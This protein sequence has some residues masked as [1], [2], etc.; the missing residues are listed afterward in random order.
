[1][2]V[3]F[4]FLSQPRLST[5]L[6]SFTSFLTHRFSSA[7]KIQQ[8]SA[9]NVQLNSWTQSFTED[10]LLFSLSSVQNLA[11]IQL[12]R[13]TLE[14][15]GTLA[16]E[17]VLIQMVASIEKDLQHIFAFPIK[18]RALV[19]VSCILLCDGGQSGAHMGRPD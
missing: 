1:M 14:T 3:S 13:Q 16:K 12:L 11:P 17:I 5:N 6:C 15:Q 10:F 7:A 2:L 8:I 18:G 19:P 9:V 4:A